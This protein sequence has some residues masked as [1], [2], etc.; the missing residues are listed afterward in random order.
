MTN[1]IHHPGPVDP[2]DSLESEPPLL[3]IDEACHNL[4]Q[5][6]KAFAER[7]AQYPDVPTHLSQ[8]E[9]WEQFFCFLSESGS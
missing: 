1:S 4:T 5:D 8:D 6:M 7:W 9:W 3:N 2:P